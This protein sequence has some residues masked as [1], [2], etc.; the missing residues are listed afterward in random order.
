MGGEAS[1]PGVVTAESSL[2]DLPIV[3]RVV[4]R[5]FV[6]A[7]RVLLPIALAERLAATRRG[8]AAGRVAST[9]LF[10]AALAAFVW[11]NLQ[12]DQGWSAG[13]GRIRSPAFKP[14][15]A[16]RPAAAAR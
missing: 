4:H 11:L 6:D 5:T 8:R 10:L 13:D 12:G 14:S 1:D 7:H 3:P 2:A 15:I 16:A 9:V